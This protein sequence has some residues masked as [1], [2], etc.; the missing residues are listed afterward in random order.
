MVKNATTA[1]ETRTRIMR[2]AFDEIYRQ[3]F[4]G[5]SL[6]RI[7]DVAETT[8]GALFHH[9]RG[10]ADLGYAIVDEVLYPE[11]KRIWVDP[12]DA[13][14]DPVGT[15][16]KIMLKMAAEC[17]GDRLCRGCPLNNLSQEMSPLDEEFRL[18]LEHIYSEWRRAIEGAF[19]R[20]IDA[21]RIR[22]E[23]K[24]KEVAAFMVAGFAGAIGT[25]KNAQDPEIMKLAGAT[26]MD[27]L[28]TLET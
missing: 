24:P 21:G 9:F 1:E 28:K 17:K 19:E 4:Q 2:T 7:V 14:D 27:F 12:L 18:R 13:T 5:A 10:K 3:G 25:A 26:L 6:N 11:V 20:G 16:R 15:L 8:K 22:R 23:V